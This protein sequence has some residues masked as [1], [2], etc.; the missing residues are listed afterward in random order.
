MF[1]SVY[2]TY[3]TARSE[4]STRRGHV[5][6]LTGHEA[7][8]DTII[9]PSNAIRRGC[10]AT[11]NRLKNRLVGAGRAHSHGRARTARS[12]TNP[13]RSLHRRTDVQGGHGKDS[14]PSCYSSVE[15]LTR[16]LNVGLRLGEPETNAARCTR[17]QAA[18]ARA[19]PERSSSAPDEGGHQ[20]SSEVIRGNLGRR[21][22]R[23]HLMREA[24][25]GHQRSSEAILAG[26]ILERTSSGTALRHVCAIRGHNHL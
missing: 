16:V 3:N 5:T 7:T 13:H 19:G 10:F 9:K 8:Y 25:R 2:R 14:S 18:A 23:A 6:R 26:E 1:G 22:P 24:I 20:R 17:C 11:T 12:C 15:V 21:D 4:S